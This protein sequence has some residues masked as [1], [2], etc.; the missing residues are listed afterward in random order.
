[1]KEISFE[2]IIANSQRFNIEV[3]VPAAHQLHDTLSYVQPFADKFLLL[4]HA[5]AQ[6]SIP[7]GLYCEFGV[8]EGTTVNFIAPLIYPEKIHGFDS[9]EG[10]PDDWRPGFPKGLFNMEARLPQVRDNVILHQGL[11]DQTLPE[12]IAREDGQ[13]A[14]IHVDCDI[15]ASAKTIFDLAGP[16]ITQGTVIVFD[17]FFNYETWE[18]HEYKAFQEFIAET[19]HRFQFIGYTP[20]NEQLA[21]KII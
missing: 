21:V 9:F 7:S 1:M 11:F 13:F 20:T 4:K 19:R 5:I 2:E 10:L 16:R 6:V 3:S 17:E 14:F 12:F 18:R 15:F 8:F